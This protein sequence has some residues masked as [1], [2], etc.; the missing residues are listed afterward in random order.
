MFC[1]VEAVN[2]SSFVRLPVC[3]FLLFV[4]T[5]TT[6][7]VLFWFLEEGYILLQG[8]SKYWKYINLLTFEIWH[9]I[10]L[11]QFIIE[12]QTKFSQCSGIVVVFINASSYN[13]SLSIFFI[14]SINLIHS[15]L[16]TVT[17]QSSLVININGARKLLT[18][19]RPIR[20]QCK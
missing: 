12:F 5:L 16:G 2:L 15:L 9:R 4:I 3:L 7:R 8:K 20:Y 1:F 14:I 6:F 17:L 18:R 13:T 11:F 10:R 19:I